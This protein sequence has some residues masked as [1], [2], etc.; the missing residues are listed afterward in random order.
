MRLDTLWW[1]REL[2]LIR[3]IADSE[4]LLLEDMNIRLTIEG[5]FF[6]TMDSFEASLKSPEI[7]KQGS[8][9][10]AEALNPPIH[11]MID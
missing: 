6:W 1:V 8:E 10:D 2:V 7:A 11:F 9:T 4:L 3:E 5:F